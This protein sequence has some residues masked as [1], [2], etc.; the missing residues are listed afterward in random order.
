[1]HDYLS[2][3]MEELSGRAIHSNVETIGILQSASYLEWCAEGNLVDV[4][5]LYTGKKIFYSDIVG[6]GKDGTPYRLELYHKFE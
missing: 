1:M 5:L 3:N 2:Q 4:E 6:Y